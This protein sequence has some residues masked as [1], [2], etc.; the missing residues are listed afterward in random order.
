MGTRTRRFFGG[1]AA[2]LL[3]GGSALN[4]ATTLPSGFTEAPWGNSIASNCTAMAFAP[5]GRLFVCTQDGHLRVIDASGNLLGPDFATLTVDSSGERGLIGVAFDPNFSTN[6]YVYVYHTVP[7]GPTNS[8]PPHNRIS[9]FTANGNVAAGGPTTIIDLDNLSS[10]TNHNGGAI[11]FGSDG[12]LYAGVGDNASGTTASASNSQKVTN[13][14]GKILRINADPVNPTPSDNPAT[15]TIYDGST[16]T[17]AG[18]NRQIW[19]IVLRN[20]FTFAFQLCTVRM[21]I[22]DVGENTLEEFNNGLAGSNYGW[23]STEGFFTQSSFPQF[24]E[25]LMEYGHGSNSTSTGCA[26]IGGG[27]YNPG[28]QQFPISYNGMFFFGDL[29]NGWIRFTDPNNNPNTTSLFASGISGQL[30]DLTVGP[31]GALYYLVRSGQVTRI[32]A[33]PSQTLNIST[34]AHIETGDNVLIGG[35]IVTGSGAK[36]VIIRAIGPSLPAALGPMADPM[37]EL[38]GPAP[39]NTLIASNDDW[40][41]PAQNQTDVQATGLQPSNDKESAIVASLQPGAYTAIMSG[42]NSSSGTGLVE[43]YDLAP[44]ASSQLG[45]ISG[46]GHVQTG[47]FVMIGGFIVGN[48][49]GAARIV[50]RALGPSLSGSV[51]SPVLA[52]PTLELHDGNGALIGFNDNW[53]DDPNQA[54]LITDAGLAPANNLESAIL[55]GLAP[56]P[57]TAIVAGKNSGTGIGLVEVYQVQ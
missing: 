6:Q 25:P 28:I 17:P 13:R 12:K 55:T 14:L 39:S 26:I 18:A 43:I 15:F 41:V 5:D 40:R 2:C 4:A 42:K 34:R 46:R 35:F 30:V 31:D 27:F 47:D 8:P 38:R 53:Q 36:N 54:A 52:D 56:G 7:A 9:R 10:A 33:A 44:A 22:V 32:Q 21:F 1:A 49:I 20:S 48:N 11:H 57:Y 23:P 37:L 16:V 3:V 45:N 24:T 50:V 51:G 19:T 29:C